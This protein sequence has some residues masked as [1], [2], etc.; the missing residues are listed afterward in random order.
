MVDIHDVLA[1]HRSRNKSSHSEVVLEKEYINPTTSKIPD[2][3]F[4]EVVVDFKLNRI[5][6]LMLMY[7][8]RRVWCRPNLYKEFGIGQLMAHSEISAQL[9]I[10]I[11]EIYHSL[12]K[13]EELGFI[14]TIRSGQ[15]FV[16]R[17]F[18][19]ENDEKFGQTYDDFEI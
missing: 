15:Y 18:T 5:E 8:Y 17:Y 14:S 19:K 13:I 10:S 16:R 9:K 12:R 11:D 7:L 6:I 1:I 3:F 4:D 2:I